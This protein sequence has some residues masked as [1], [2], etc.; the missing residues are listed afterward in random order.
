MCVLHPL[1]PFWS[2]RRPN[3]AAR[4]AFWVPPDTKPPRNLVVA[5]MRFKF[6]LSYA[7]RLHSCHSMWRFQCIS[8]TKIGLRQCRGRAKQ[9]THAPS[10]F[11]VFFKKLNAETQ[12]LIYCLKHGQHISRITIDHGNRPINYKENRP[13]DCPVVPGGGGGG[14]A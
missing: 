11:A 10:P 13:P 14:P 5:M 1:P 2:C 7:H 9:L 3:A 8:G 12:G 6:C 4:V